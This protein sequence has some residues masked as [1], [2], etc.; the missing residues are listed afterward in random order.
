MAPVSQATRRRENGDAPA[1]R[2]TP[3][4]FHYGGFLAGGPPSAKLKPPLGGTQYFQVAPRNLSS[5]RSP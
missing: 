1:V 5:T 2:K 3:G 4:S